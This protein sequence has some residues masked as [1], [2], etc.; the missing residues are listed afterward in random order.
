MRFKLV[1]VVVLVGLLFAA[2]GI[3]SADAGGAYLTRLKV[4]ISGTS[5]WQYIKIGNSYIASYHVDATAPG[6]TVERGSTTLL[7][8]GP[9]YQAVSVTITFLLEVSNINSFAV[10]LAKGKIGE[11]HAKLYRVNDATPVQI[12]SLNNYETSDDMA[13]TVQVSRSALVGTGYTVPRIDPRR[14]VLA[15][16]YPWFQAGSF[17]KGPWYDEP[18]GAYDTKDPTQVAEMVTQAQTAG[19]D[20]MIVSWDNIGDHAQRFDL[21]TAE[22]AKRSM[23][24]SPLIELMAFKTSAGFNLS[25]IVSTIKLALERST[26][27][28]FLKVGGRPVVFVYGAWELEPASWKS[29]VSTLS[30]AGL[31]PFLIGEPSD[32]AYGFDGAYYYNPN[33]H[34]Y[35]FLISKYGAIMRQLRYAAQV[36]PLV[37][38]GLWAATVSPGQNMSYF[39]PLFPQHENRKNGDRYDLTWSASFSTAPEWILVTSWNEWYEATHIVPSQK[40]GSTA[41]NQTAGWADAFHNPTPWGGSSNSGGLLPLPGPLGLNLGAA[42]Q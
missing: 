11:A 39:D 21:V 25:G 41:L 8:R 38:Q 3:N 6:A 23:H 34:S 2:F 36:D 5:D 29:V 30:S 1:S 24:V 4:E 37:K 19:I 31:S 32:A 40:F 13:V 17:D 7:V 14:L 20:G 15:F 22:L 33:G 10:T 9:G 27:P 35:S 28:A 12:L 16:Y 18:T 42:G 26:N